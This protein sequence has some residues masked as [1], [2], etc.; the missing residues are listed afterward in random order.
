MSL[1]RCTAVHCTLK[2]NHYRD[3]RTR[4]I[5]ISVIVVNLVSRPWQGIDVST[6]LRRLNGR[7][8]EA[9]SSWNQACIAVECLFQRYEARSVYR[10][11]YP[12]GDRRL[13]AARSARECSCNGPT[14]TIVLNSFFCGLYQ[15]ELDMFHFLPAWDSSVTLWLIVL[16]NVEIRHLCNALISPLSTAEERETLLAIHFI[17]ASSAY[18]ELWWHSYRFSLSCNKRDV[19][20]WRGPVDC[21]AW[22]YPKMKY[23]PE[24]PGPQ[25]TTADQFTTFS[26]L[27]WQKLLMS[28]SVAV[29]RSSF[30][31]MDIIF[32][33]DECLILYIFLIFV[34][35]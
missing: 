27:L 15:T 1:L 5:G 16:K 24:E 29:S 22:F 13:I 32:C 30:E 8:L 12:T 19:T 20:C 31:M 34:F 3:K 14:G 33:A 10:S 7:E 26:M 11:T 23:F 9:T 4:L 6:A 25:R 18:A 21:E 35:F 28:R 2:S 17:L